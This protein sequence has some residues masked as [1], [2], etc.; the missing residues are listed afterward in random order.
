MYTYIYF[1]HKLKHI[2]IPSRKNWYM[3]ECLSKIGVS[4]CDTSFIDV[5]TFFCLS[6]VVLIILVVVTYFLYFIKKN[7]NNKENKE[8]GWSSLVMDHGSGREKLDFF[9][10]F[11]LKF[12]VP[13]VC[14]VV[15]RSMDMFLSVL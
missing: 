13:S 1:M 14:N 12:N 6:A 2:Y 8:S 9:L 10:Q 7:N 4:I 3:A 11:N 5:T 15:V